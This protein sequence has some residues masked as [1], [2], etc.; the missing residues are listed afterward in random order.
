MKI[1]LTKAAIKDAVP[2]L[3]KVVPT[4][5]NLAVLNCVRFAVSGDC[6]TATATDL[7]QTLV[8]A[9]ATAQ[10]EGQGEIIVPYAALKELAKGDASDTVT[11]EQDGDS[12]IVTNVVGGHAVTITVPGTDPRDWP[13]SGPEIEVQEAKG[14]IKA[15]RRMA[16]FASA[17]ETRRTLQCVYVD[18]CGSG[19]HNATLVAT[20]GRRL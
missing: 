17:D 16:P 5:T 1:T 9:F 12:V 7:D 3:G 6:L 15:Y 11:L 18:V 20:D 2:G 8:Y 14:F 19:D 13:E 4:R 10:C